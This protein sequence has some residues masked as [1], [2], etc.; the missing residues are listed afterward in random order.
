[1]GDYP[2]P[3]FGQALCRGDINRTVCQNYFENARLEIL[4][5]CITD[6]EAII[7]VLGTLLPVSA[8]TVGLAAWGISKLAAVLGK[9]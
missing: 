3:V 4:I 6:A 9:L 1:M 8:T 7:C 2:N 5:K